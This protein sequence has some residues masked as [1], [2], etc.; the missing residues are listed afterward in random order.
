M[1]FNKHINW[2]GG[3]FSR[4]SWKTVYVFIKEFNIKSVLEYGCGLSTEL[5][6]AIGMEVLSLET[7]KEFMDIPE[8]K[9]ILC[10]YYNYPKLDRRF[11]LAFVDGPGAYEFESKKKV[12]ERRNSILH[13]KQYVNYIYMHDGGMGQI[14]PL[15]NDSNWMKCSK[16]HTEKG[17]KDI[18]YRR[19]NV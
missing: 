18:F 5:L 17:Y 12:P 13:A 19:K 6:L 14:E 9:I 1:I 2:G 11:D 7:R 8:A 15:E 3:G 10:D 16:G 4:D